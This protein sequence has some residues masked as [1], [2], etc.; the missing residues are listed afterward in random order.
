MDKHI[1]EV[2]KDGQIKYIFEKKNKII[3]WIKK[4]EKRLNLK[5]M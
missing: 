1:N 3:N 4:D 5:T 2:K